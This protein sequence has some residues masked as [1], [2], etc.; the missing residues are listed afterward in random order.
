MAKR[1]YRSAKGKIIDMEAMRVANEKT[2]A[3]G[4]MGVNAKG[5]LIEGG[6]VVQTAK[7]RVTPSYTKVTQTAEVSMKKP[8][9]R[10]DS[11]EVTPKTKKAPEPMEA[12]MTTETVKTRDDGTKY[13]E[14]LNPDGDIEVKDIDPA[15]KKKA[16][17]KK[18]SNKTKRPLV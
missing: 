11:E 8:L 9:S 4:N 6:K 10:S 3:A 12:E 5:D 15:P 16:P 17:K 7:E 18:T 1:T 13:R 2:V 14:V